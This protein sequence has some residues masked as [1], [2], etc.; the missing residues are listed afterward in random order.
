MG[1]LIEKIVLRNFLMQEE[2]EEMNRKK[3]MYVYYIGI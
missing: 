1:W 2:E 3:V